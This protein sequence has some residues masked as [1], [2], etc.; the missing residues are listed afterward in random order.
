MNFIFLFDSKKKSLNDNGNGKRFPIQFRKK[1]SK[2]LSTTTKRNNIIEIT[3]THTSVESFKILIK[4]I[5]TGT[6]IFEGV[7]PSTIFDLLVPSN[8]L[9]LAELKMFD[10]FKAREIWDKVI[11]WRK[12]QTPNLPSNF[13]QWNNENFLALK[14]TLEKKCI[15]LI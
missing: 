13:E 10:S 3:L 6:I 5:Y 12:E 9:G 4:Y 2:E 14:T 1:S 11:Q 15:P 7:K 8:K